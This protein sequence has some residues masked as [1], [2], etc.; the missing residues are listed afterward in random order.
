MANPFVII[1]AINTGKGNLLRQDDPP[2]YNEFLTNRAMS[3]F[4]DTIF[5][6]YQ[7]DLLEDLEPEILMDY[8]VNSVRPKKRFSKWH[9]PVK[10]D[11]ID[12]L[13]NL[14]SI[15]IKIAGEYLSILTSDQLIQLKEQYNTGGLNGNGTDRKVESGNHG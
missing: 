1:D 5:Q 15:N 9:K 4:P 10:S 11:D 2:E 13:K 12:F 14:Y 8:Y 7:A 3:Q 6:S